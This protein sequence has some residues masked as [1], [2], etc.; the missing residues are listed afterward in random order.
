M[1]TPWAVVEA[2]EADRIEA[3]HPLAHRLRMQTQLV[4]N[5]EHGL[6]WLA[7]QIMR[8]RSTSRA[9]AVRE[10]A[11]R[12]SMVCSSGVSSRTRSIEHPFVQ[13]T[14]I[15]PDLSDGPLSKYQ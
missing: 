1:A 7:C 11:S 8:A 4:G 2:G 12:S 9:A 6:A 3:L 15:V 14:Q 10:W 5:R 13:Y